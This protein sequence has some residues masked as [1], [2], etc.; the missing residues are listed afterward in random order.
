MSERNLA[1]QRAISDVEQCINKLPDSNALE[2]QES[3]ENHRVRISDAFENC[4]NSLN[5]L[6]QVLT[7]IETARK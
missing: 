5:A 3:S 2:I 6:R 1:L 7:E 4:F